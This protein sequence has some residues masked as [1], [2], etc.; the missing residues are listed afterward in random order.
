MN[1]V[2]SDFSPVFS[3]GTRMQT[4]QFDRMTLWLALALITAPPFRRACPLRRRAG[5]LRCGDRRAVYRESLRRDRPRPRC[6]LIGGKEATAA[7][8]RYRAG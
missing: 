2:T 3:A 1:V 7:Q 4:D 8:V 6:G 5:N